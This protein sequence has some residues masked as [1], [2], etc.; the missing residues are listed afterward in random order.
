MNPIVEKG[1]RVAAPRRH[2]AEVVFIG[3]APHAVFAYLDDFQNLGGHMSQ[4]SM[5]MMGSRLRLERV[6]E[7]ATGVGARY[8][9]H[10]RILGLPVDLTEVVTEWRLD[11]R[12]S[13]QTVGAPRL[14]VMAGYRMGFSVVPGDGGSLLTIEI[15]YDIPRSPIGRLLS[16]LLGDAYARWCLRRMG[17]DAKAALERRGG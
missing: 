9:W 3:A 16:W 1:E 4:R 10:G 15:E 12:K 14:I 17:R 2:L 11:Q 6:S 8:R 5:A 7:H 13:W